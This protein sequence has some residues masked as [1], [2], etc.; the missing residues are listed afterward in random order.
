MKK[1]DMT[2][3]S[4]V[5]RV[6]HTAGKYCDR[7]IVVT[8]EKGDGYE[9]G[10]N[11]GLEAG[12]K[13]EYDRFWDVYQ[14]NGS[15]VDYTYAFYNRGWSD[16]SYNPKYD[17]APT[18]CNGLFSFSYITDTKVVVDLSNTKK[19]SVSKVFYYCYWLKTIRKLIVT[20]NVPLDTKFFGS[21][22]ALE[23][24]TFEGVI[25]QNLSLVDSPL[26]T[27][28][29]VQSVIEHLQNLTEQSACTLTLHAD[30]GAN[31]T[32]AQKAAITAKNWTLVY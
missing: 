32:Q 13:A 6:L 15:R 5:T 22:P 10:Y 21:C 2:I 24:I 26:L 11:E 8:A 17:I 1:V 31:L 3:Q 9:N 14:Q 4:G 30:V 25:G 27:D 29:S 20:E 16:Q 18:D 19:D 28:A 7:D 23:N 12:K